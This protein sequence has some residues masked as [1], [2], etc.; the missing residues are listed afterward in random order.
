MSKRY[1]YMIVKES[2]IRGGV[3][4]VI[5]VGWRTYASCDKCREDMFKAMHGRVTEKY[6]Q[7]NPSMDDEPTLFYLK[8][9]EVCG[10]YGGWAAREK[11]LCALRPG[12]QSEINKYFTRFPED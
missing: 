8:L 9:Y 1:S 7:S 3:D 2:D 6:I 10:A 11:W 12:V 5:D 4:E